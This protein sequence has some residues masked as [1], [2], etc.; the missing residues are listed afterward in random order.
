MKHFCHYNA[1]YTCTWFV[2]TKIIH[3]FIV[4]G[5]LHTNCYIIDCKPMQKL[6]D[7]I[8]LNSWL[9][10]IFFFV[11]KIKCVKTKQW[12]QKNVLRA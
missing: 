2:R 7:W 9:L 4:Y 6:D 12:M 11:N 8:P 5:M 3:L 10:K 1:G